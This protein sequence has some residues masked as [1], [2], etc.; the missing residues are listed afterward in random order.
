MKLLQRAK[1]LLRYKI[2]ASRLKKR[3]D[4]KNGRIGKQ[5]LLAGIPD[6]QNI[7]DMAIAVAQMK[8]LERMGVSYAALTAAECL[9][10]AELLEN[11]VPENTPILYQGGGNIGNVWKRDEYFRRKMLSSF[12]KNPSVI[13]PQ[14]IFYTNDEEGK[15][16]AEWGAEYYGKCLDLTVF[17]REAPSLERGKE[18]FSSADVRFCPDVVLTLDPSD[19]GVY[20]GERNGVLICLRNDLESSV[21]DSALENIAELLAGIGLDYTVTDTIYPSANIDTDRLDVIVADKLKEFISAKL[22]ITDRLHGMI[23]SAIC[24]T[25]CIVLG[26]YN[27]K[28]ERTADIL[29][30]LPYIRFAKDVSEV[31]ALVD[32]LYSLEKCEYDISSLKEHYVALEN[33]IRRRIG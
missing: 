13:F 11:I 19:I 14:T 9:D 1:G 8:L 33:E 22:V 5:V 29:S 21:D 17:L 31:E 3:L 27:H 2:G 20:E 32:G 10:Y 15:R 16:E 24:R 6:Y 7:G 28:V 26:N 12:T 25:P 30:C 23:F 4:C 18:L